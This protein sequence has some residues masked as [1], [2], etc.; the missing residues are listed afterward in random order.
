LY[1]L[2]RSNYIFGELIIVWMRRAGHLARLGEKRNAYRIGGKARRKRPPGRPRRR[3]VN[4]IKID[5][6]EIGWNAVD[7]IDVAQDRV[8]WRTLVI[9]V[10]NLRV[11]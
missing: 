8:Q 4:N 9:K 1:I 11:A 3:W 6:R 2:F 10:L 5:L 7:W